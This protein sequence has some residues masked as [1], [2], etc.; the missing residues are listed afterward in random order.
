MSQDL[1][2]ID[3]LQTRRAGE[4][5]RVPHGEVIVVAEAE[6]EL[7]SGFEGKGAVAVQ[8]NFVAQ[9]G[10]FRQHLWAKQQHGLDKPGLYLGGQICLSCDSLTVEA[11]LGGVN[12]PETNRSLMVSARRGL[13]Q[14]MRASTV[15]SSQSISAHHTADE[16]PDR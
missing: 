3:P 15:G 1:Q 9:F 10:S 4:H 14:E 8:L 5:R 2:F 7:S 12:P 6:G 16:I 11:A 13:W